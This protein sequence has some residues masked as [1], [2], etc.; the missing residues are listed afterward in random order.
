MRVTRSGDPKILGFTVAIWHPRFLYHFIKLLLKSDVWY[1]MHFYV[2]IQK[3]ALQNGQ[4]YGD[5][6]ETH[7]IISLFLNCR[8]LRSYV[9]AL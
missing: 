3:R 5:K 1:R 8:Y 9:T 6:R 7:E 2:D 4:N